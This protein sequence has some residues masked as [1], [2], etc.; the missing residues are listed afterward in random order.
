MLYTIY[1]Y[2][3]VQ[4]NHVAVL[5]CCKYL[6]AFNFNFEKQLLD[7]SIHKQNK[8]RMKTISIDLRTEVAHT[9]FFKKNFGP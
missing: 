4:Y 1:I 5:S 2:V 7:Y 3:A 9:I 6:G 8:K